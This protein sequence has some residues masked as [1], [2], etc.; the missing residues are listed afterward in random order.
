MRSP[1]PSVRPG[2]R[3][4]PSPSPSPSL[5]RSPCRPRRVARKVALPLAHVN[6]VKQCCYYRCGNCRPGRLSIRPPGGAEGPVGHGAGSTFGLAC[7]LVPGSLRNSP[8]DRTEGR[9]K[10][11]SGI[12]WRNCCPSPWLAG[13]VPLGGG[14]MKRKL[15]ATFRS[16][17]SALQANEALASKVQRLQSEKFKMFVFCLWAGCNLGRP[18]ARNGSSEN[19]RRFA[20]RPLSSPRARSLKLING[21][22]VW[23]A[24]AASSQPAATCCSR[25]P[26]GSPRWEPSSGGTR[27]DNEWPAA[28]APP[29]R[30]AYDLFASA[31]PS[32]LISRARSGGRLAGS[33]SGR[34]RPK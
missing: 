13:S 25:R 23:P 10:S 34:R 14:E 9:R 18:R 1:S 2:L 8:P 29:G 17:I 15:K 7:G 30:P 6:H 5:R 12:R 24:P 32:E 33:T 11:A 4:S 16:Q 21:W 3:P 27:A 20:Q 22:L 28:A 31:G 19:F 26:A